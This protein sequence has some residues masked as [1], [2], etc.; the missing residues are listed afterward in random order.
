MLKDYPYPSE[1]PEIF[2]DDNGIVNVIFG[3]L[4][5]TAAHV[6]HTVAVQRK[7]A[8]GKKLPIMIVGEAA[9]DVHGAISK[10]G[11]TEWVTEVTT[12]LAV[13]TQS[14]ISRVMGKVFISLQKKLI[15]HQVIRL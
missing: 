11:N 13:V 8:P 6:A 5:V 14:K 3:T 4:M 10:V 15:S 2:I 12:A 9:L 1:M 7:L